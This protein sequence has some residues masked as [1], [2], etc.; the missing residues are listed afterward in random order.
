M[1]MNDRFYV[2]AQTLCLSHFISTSVQP[3]VCEFSPGNLF[4]SYDH[5]VFYIIPE[6]KTLF[7]K[8]IY[9]SMAKIY[10][11]KNFEN[12]KQAIYPDA[13]QPVFLT[14]NVKNLTFGG[15]IVELKT[16]QNELL[17]ISGE[18]LSPFPKKLK[19][20]TS[21]D[22]SGPVFIYSALKTLLGGVYPVK[23]NC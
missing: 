21:I 20:L 8:S 23:A 14:G 7:D 3:A 4:V 2:K 9:L 1:N 13:F 22:L 10:P 19:F 12:M 6:N 11:D 17:W 5:A 15:T 18:S 16:N